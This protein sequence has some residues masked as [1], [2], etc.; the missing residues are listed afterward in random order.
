MQVVHRR[1]KLSTVPKKGLTIVMCADSLRNVQSVHPVLMTP[2]EAADMLRVHRT[3]VYRLIESGELRASR[4]GGQ[5][6]IAEATLLELLNG[7]QAPGA[8]VAS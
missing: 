4:I 7:G 6:R 3:T 8:E 1:G 2:E 5:W